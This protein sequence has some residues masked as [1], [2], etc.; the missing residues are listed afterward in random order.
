[1]YCPKCR[2]EYVDGFTR[3]F[4]C[5]LPLVDELP[6]PSRRARET[7][8]VDRSQPDAPPRD[9]LELVTVLASGDPGLMAVAT[10]LLRSADIPFL[11]QGEGVQ[12][13][14]GVG[15][16]GSGF[17][18]VTGPARLQVGADDAADARELLADLIGD[19]DHD[20]RA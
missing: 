15:R 9:D 16:I 7:R 4:D 14:F 19:Q 20:G 11:V 18:I 12:D 13:L 5:D 17:N 1:M 6:P 8:A 2:A 10:S 3:C